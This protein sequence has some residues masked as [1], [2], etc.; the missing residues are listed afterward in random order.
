VS[1]D[2]FIEQL[3]SSGLMSAAE[4]QAFHETLPSNHKPDDG[5]GLARELVQANRLTRYQAAAVCQGKILGLVFGEYR[6]LDTLGQGGM[7]VVLKAEHQRMKRLVAV[8]MIAAWALQSPDAVGRFYR[9]VE[10][11]ARL[12]HPNIVHAYDAGQY[13]GTH[14]L[15][16]EYVEGWDL[17]TIVRE[18]GA[19]PIAAAVDCMVQAARGLAYAHEE[20]IVHRDIKPAN[21]LLDRKGTVKVLDMG[22]ARLAGRD[23]EDRERLTSTSQVIGTCDY[24]APEQAVDTHAVD[25]RADIYSLGCTLYRLLSGQVPYQGET[26]IQTLLKH[27]QSPIPSLRSVRAEV[28]PELDAVCQRMLAKRV[29]DR[30][31]SMAEVIADLERCA[32]HRPGDARSLAERLRLGDL[33]RAENVCPGQECPCES[34]ATLA[35]RKAKVIAEPTPVLPSHAAVRRRPFAAAVGL[36]LAGIAVLVLAAVA[37]RL[38]YP[39][40]AQTLPR[41][42]RSRLHGWPWPR[43]TQPRPTSIKRPGPSTWACR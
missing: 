4:V 25:Q 16:M 12:N 3:A 24:M 22:L 38:R 11:A 32:V 23:G 33:A 1:L 31:Q 14:Y 19:L 9:E 29:E 21:L 41:A 6:V 2:R 28:S 7:G 8:K 39:D 27:Q 34:A 20:G 5:E 26:A 17:A 36:V 40:R 10:A 30:Q 18:Q 15:V 42:A 13:E 35:D 43:S 37:I